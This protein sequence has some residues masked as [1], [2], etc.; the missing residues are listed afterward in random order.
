MDYLISFLPLILIIACCVLMP[1]LMMR[2]GR[3][4]NEHSSAGHGGCCGGG[5]GKD[6][7]ANESENKT[8]ENNNHQ[9]C[10]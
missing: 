1:Y 10:H 2:K 7:P 6:A 4:E 5:K 3:G 8:A 9:S